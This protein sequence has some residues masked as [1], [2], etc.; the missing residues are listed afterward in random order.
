MYVQYTPGQ[1]ICIYICVHVHIRIYVSAVRCA[2]SWVIAEPFVPVERVT[3]N[4]I[5]Y[6]N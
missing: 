6:M 4:Q 3:A 2:P 5:R 1:P